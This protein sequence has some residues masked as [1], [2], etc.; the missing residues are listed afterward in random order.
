[1]KNANIARKMIESGRWD[2]HTHSHSHAHTHT[3]TH[4]HTFTHTQV[5]TSNCDGINYAN[6]NICMNFNTLSC[7]ECVCVYSWMFDSINQTWY[8]YQNADFELKHFFAGNKNINKHLFRLWST[9][10][11]AKNETNSNLKMQ[12]NFF[13]NRLFTVRHEFSLA[14]IL[15]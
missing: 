13:S 15:L 6:N 2:T 8:D 5:H 12:I 4:I 14:P 10:S 3:H 7:W 1:M 9:C 11:W